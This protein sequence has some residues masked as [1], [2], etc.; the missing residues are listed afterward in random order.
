[1]SWL[2][3]YRRST[4]MHPSQPDA[5]L[6]AALDALLGEHPAGLSEYDLMI[7]LDQRYGP[8]YPKPNLADPILLFQHHFYLR[9]SLY[10]LQSHYQ[11]TGTATLLITALTI[12]KQLAVANQHTALPDRLE[13]LKDYYLDLANLNRESA[14][15]VQQLLD[16][17]WRAL[18]GHQQQPEALATL[19][20]SGRESA[21]EQKQQYR[22]LVQQHHPDK[23]GD[24]EQFRLIQAAWEQLR[25]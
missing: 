3:S 7:L 8:L 25:S 11:Q 6:L 13:P 2:W 4:L 5:R 18:R 19:G 9:H 23:G 1:M 22:L 15:S 21:A 20:L 24:A 12:R 16:D 10:L 14:D 17:F